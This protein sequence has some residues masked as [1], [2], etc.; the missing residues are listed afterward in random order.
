MRVV[1]PTFAVG[2][3]IPRIFQ[4]SVPVG[5]SNFQSHRTMANRRTVNGKKTT[6]PHSGTNGVVQPPDPANKEWNKQKQLLDIVLESIKS[7]RCT[8]SVS[9]P[10]SSSASVSPDK[11]KPLPVTISISDSSSTS[12]DG[13][14]D[15][16]GAESSSAGVR[17]RKGPSLKAQAVMVSQEPQAVVRRSD[18]VSKSTKRHADGSRKLA[19]PSGQAK[20]RN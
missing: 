20:V 11:K 17:K 9:P 18:S 19:A 15:D 2:E 16:S 13:K 6:V 7:T 14:E 8:I 4:I 12:S 10:R 5:H 1:R 3:E